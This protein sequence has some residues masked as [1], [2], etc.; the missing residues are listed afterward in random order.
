MV[1]ATYRAG[2]LGVLAMAVSGCGA[3]ASSPP[4]GVA[5]STARQ[6]GP[7]PNA[8]EAGFAWLAPAP[9]PA[10]WRSARLATGATIAYPPDWHT[11]PGDRGTA[12]AGLFDPRGHYLAYLNLTPRQGAETLAGWAAFRVRHNVGEGDREVKSD[13]AAGGLRF[14]TG[15]GTCVRDAYTTSANTRYVEIACLVAGPHATS[16]AVGAAPREHWNE[17]QS[18]I[19][20]A[21]SAVIT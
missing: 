10:D 6:A 14:L 20:R 12:S 11:L 4:P 15:H 3:S 1:T 13:G 2:L 21:L 17:E 8:A 18:V 16:V 9:A 7:A 19:E 5:A